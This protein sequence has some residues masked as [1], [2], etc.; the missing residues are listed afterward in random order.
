[1]IHIEIWNAKRDAE[2]KF[3][4]FDYTDSKIDLTQ[5]PKFYDKVY[6]YTTDEYKDLPP[7]RVLNRLY[8]K[9]NLYRPDDFRGHSMSVSDIIT[10]DGVPYYCDSFGFKEI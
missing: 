3:M 2:F 10:L 8:E 1:M 5:Y 4:N 9:F 6:E 7:L